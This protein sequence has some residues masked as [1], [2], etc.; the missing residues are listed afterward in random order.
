[1]AKAGER[2]TD[3]PAGDPFDLNRF[4]L[5][6]AD[7][8]IFLAAHPG[9][10]HFLL[11]AIDPSVTDETDPLSC[12]PALDLF[13]PANGFNPNGASHY[14][15]EFRDRYYRAQ[16]RVMNTRI[17]EVEANLLMELRA[18]WSIADSL[19]LSEVPL[20]EVGPANR[21]EKV[22]DVPRYL[23]FEEVMGKDHC[24]MERSSCGTHLHVDHEDDLVGEYNLLQSMDP[25]FA[26]MSSSSFMRGRNTVNCGRV[27]S[28]RN[29]SYAAAP[30]MC[31]LS[32]YVSSTDE[33]DSL[34]AARSGYFLDRLQ[35]TAEN[36]RIFGSYN[37]GSSP[38][39]K[40]NK[41]IEIRSADSN[42]PSMVLAMAAL[43]KGVLR[44]VF[45]SPGLEIKIASIGALWSATGSEIFLP[46]YTTLRMMESEGL[47]FGP[48]SK[49]VNEY[50]SYLVTLADEGLP[51]T[52]SKYLRPFREILRRKRNVAHVIHEKAR[53]IDSTTPGSI[54]AACAARVNRFVAEQYK[55]NIDGGSQLI[56]MISYG[57]E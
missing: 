20:S 21:S 27:S 54:T 24:D 56:D 13:D 19:G 22:L 50:L 52:E 1:M 33:I 53:L 30:H 16:S 46:S 44:R 25:V 36:R 4:E 31:Q 29:E 43:Y 28:Y 35:P 9:E 23:L 12:D 49:T 11:H 48:A 6:S 51:S 34:Q 17:A 15:D 55:D 57:V 32:Q 45:G 37:N 5:P 2:F 39:R 41:T 14:S 26:L 40:T 18:V 3:T 47:A 42:I 38:I 7:G 10:G 8:M